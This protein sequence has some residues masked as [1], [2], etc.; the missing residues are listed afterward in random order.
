MAAAV[1]GG[2]S[3]RGR[4]PRHVAGG[5]ACE[6][7]SSRAAAEFRKRR[8]VGGRDSRQP[9]AGRRRQEMGS[10]G[11]RR[12][13][14]HLCETP[15]RAAPPWLVMVAERQQVHLEDLRGVAPPPPPP[16]RRHHPNTRRQEAAAPA[17]RHGAAPDKRSAPCPR[18]ARHRGRRWVAHTSPSGRV[19]TG[20]ERAGGGQGCREIHTRSAGVGVT[21]R[22]VR[23]NPKRMATCRKHRLMRGA[24]G[25]EKVVNAFSIPSEVGAT[26]GG[27][28]SAGLSGAA[29]GTASHPLNACEEFGGGSDSR[30]PSVMGVTA[31]IET[32]RHALADGC[33]C[34]PAM[35]GRRQRFAQGVAMRADAAQTPRR[36][37]CVQERG[38]WHGTQGH[39]GGWR[40]R[41]DVWGGPHA[42]SGGRAPPRGQR[43]T[44]RILAG[45][46]K[47][48]IHRRALTTNSGAVG[49]HILGGTTYRAPRLWAALRMLRRAR[50]AARPRALH[51]YFDLG[52]RAPAWGLHD[53]LGAPFGGC[54]KQ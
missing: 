6:T 41:E 9:A 15:A 26:T 36:S 24:T 22:V 16:S 39:T 51:V 11:D 7:R 28:L 50:R 54:L 4:Y 8:Q 13:Q 48:K 27:S 2:Q 23:K 30:A 53:V 37:R 14:F 49:V 40:C 52:G 10:S 29:V 12:R 43:G 44:R 32:V 25:G 33:D 20:G 34:S 31:P 21:M 19:F 18:W 35:P 46:E 3:G 5:G 42:R 45:R 47:G 17:S 1:G 38:R